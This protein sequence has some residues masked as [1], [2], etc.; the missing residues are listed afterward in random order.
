MN[1]TTFKEKSSEWQAP[2]FVVD[3]EPIL[4]RLS[5]NAKGLDSLDLPGVYIAVDGFFR[6]L[7]DVDVSSYRH[8]LGREGLAFFVEVNDSRSAIRAYLNNLKRYHFLGLAW[9]FTIIEGSRLTA[10]TGDPGR[11]RPLTGSEL[12]DLAMTHLSMGS[13]PL[14]YSR[15]F[16]YSA[17][18]PF[19]RKRGY[20]TCLMDR[21]DAKGRE[22]FYMVLKGLDVLRRAYQ[23]IDFSGM[24]SLADLRSRGK[25]LQKAL[26]DMTGLTGFMKGILFQ[27]LIF[28]WVYEQKTPFAEIPSRIQDLCQDLDRD[29]DLD[30]RSPGVEAFRCHGVGGIRA[31]AMDGF[32]PLIDQVLPMHDIRKNLDDLSL[33]LLANTVDTT[34]LADLSMSD[35]AGIQQLAR[36]AIYPGD[37]DREAM[38]EFF[39]KRGLVTNGIRDLVM[40]TQLLALMKQEEGEE[41]DNLPSQE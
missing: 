11:S 32:R 19:I 36:R 7:R 41:G 22:N 9:N 30:V 38:D 3:R 10:I 26:A 4:V 23:S 17:L 21:E 2:F 33:F 8:S 6:L 1:R 24:T 39:Y 31:L 5:V 14:R 15:Y 16:L 12:E 13:R 34:T 40:T 37:T 29:F 18:A 35:Y 27:S 28:A 20:G 25:L